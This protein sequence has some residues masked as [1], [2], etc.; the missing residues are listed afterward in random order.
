MGT[1][2]L[3]R[4]KGFTLME[5]VVVV[6]ILAIVAAMA[7]PSVSEYTNK[8]KIINA[9]EAVYGHIQFARSQAISRSDK[10]YVKFDYTDD[11]A[12]IDASTWLVG[13]HDNEVTE[14]CDLTQDATPL[15]FSDDCH[16]VVSD[17]DADEDTGDGTVDIDDLVYYTLRGAD[18]NGVLLDADGNNAT[19]GAPSSFSFDPVRGTR[20]N[21]V[22]AGDTIY[23]GLQRSDTEWFELRVIVNAVGRVR[24]CTPN[25]ANAVPGYSTC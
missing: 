7:L 16:L 9:A 24:I 4:A 20:E 23:I 1:L 10:I 3:L 17:G 21:G 13:L 2:T 19:D 5:L 15:D 14:D 6:G 25:N 8:Q 12:P 18:F 11:T 22:G